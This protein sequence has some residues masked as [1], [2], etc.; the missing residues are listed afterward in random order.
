VIK[1]EVGEMQDQTLSIQKTIPARYKWPLVTI[2]NN[3]DA[4]V[5]AYKNATHLITNCEFDCPYD[6][7]LERDIIAYP[8]PVTENSHVDFGHPIDAT[9]DDTKVSVFHNIMYLQGLMGRASFGGTATHIHIDAPRSVLNISYGRSG[10]AQ[11]RYKQLRVFS[12]INVTGLPFVYN[13]IKDKY[14]ILDIFRYFEYKAHDP[15]T[16]K[17]EV[18]D[19]LYELELTQSF[20]VGGRAD[21]APLVAKPSRWAIGRSRVEE[22]DDPNFS[23]SLATF[24]ALEMLNNNLTRYNNKYGVTHMSREI[25][26]RAKIEYKKL[27]NIAIGGDWTQ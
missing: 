3:L 1:T 7:T 24:K 20:T 17:D 15:M 4:A 25:Y 22:H 11:V 27:G 21:S 10:K 12:D 8:P 13:K 19:L 6:E 14:L 9:T 23:E 2:G 26:E 18:H 16:I 5:F